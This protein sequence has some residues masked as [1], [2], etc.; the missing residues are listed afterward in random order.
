MLDII[1]CIYLLVLSL[2]V[3][4]VKKKQKNSEM[5]V[6]MCE[7]VICDLASNVNSKALGNAFNIF[8]WDLH[9]VR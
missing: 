9:E 6:C 4:L 1:K 7:C 3:I 8:Y 2:N 5:I